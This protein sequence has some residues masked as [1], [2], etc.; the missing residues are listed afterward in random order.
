VFQTQTQASFDALKNALKKKI[1]SLPEGSED[2]ER[3]IKVLARI[4][5]ED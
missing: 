5:R 4:K 2:R 1:E 3:W